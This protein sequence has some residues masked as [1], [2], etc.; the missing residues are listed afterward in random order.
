VVIRIKYVLI[1]VLIIL[2]L[3]ALGN[4]RNNTEGGSTLDALS[5][6]E[7]SA[8]GK[9]NGG[10]LSF[11]LTKAYISNDDLV[12][13]GI[14]CAR[15]SNQ[16][17][18]AAAEIESYDWHA[19]KIIVNQVAF[20][21]LV[22]LEVPVSGLPFVICLGRTPVYSGAFWTMLSSKRFSGVVIKTPFTTQGVVK[23]ELGYPDSEAFEGFDPRNN[24]FIRE[25][26]SQIGKLR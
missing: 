19:H 21:R 4:C 10:P 8:E 9:H 16:P 1:G 12:E 6:S 7:T 26:L 2:A 13:S 17:M 18:I 15:L 24:P 14:D 22:K 3:F 25:Y 20:E 11:Y 23:L 5:I